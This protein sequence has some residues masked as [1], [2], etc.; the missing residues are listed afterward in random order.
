MINWEVVGWTCITL[1][2]LLS[3]ISLIIYLFGLR[4]MKKS[5]Q[6]VGSVQTNLK[7]GSQILFANGFYGTVVAIPDEEKLR[8]EIAPKVQV[9]ISRYAV[10][11]IV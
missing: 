10:Q 1:A 9:E 4:N 6:T 3:L 5:R 7:V 8:V 11:K 2:V